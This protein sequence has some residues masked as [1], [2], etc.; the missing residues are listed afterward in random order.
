M[1]RLLYIFDGGA[2]RMAG[3][4][5]EGFI[6]EVSFTEREGERRSELFSEEVELFI[7]QIGVFIRLAMQLAG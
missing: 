3:K 4:F 5:H 2:Q 7:Y 1:R 6:I